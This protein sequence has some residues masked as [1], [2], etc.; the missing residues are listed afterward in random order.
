MLL[1]TTS[2]VLKWVKRGMKKGA[3]RK[4]KKQKKKR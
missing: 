4:K 2:H 1:V 3:R